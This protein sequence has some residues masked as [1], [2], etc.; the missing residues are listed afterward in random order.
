MKTLETTRPGQ[1]MT[2]R[3]QELVDLLRRLLRLCDTKQARIDQLEELLARL[4][5]TCCQLQGRLE[6]V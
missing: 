2:Q 6:G 1:T 3:E 4:N 5:D